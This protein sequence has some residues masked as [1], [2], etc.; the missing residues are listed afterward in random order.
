MSMLFHHYKQLT[1]CVEQVEQIEVKLERLLLLEKEK[2]G[3]EDHQ[4]YH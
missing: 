2:E 4:H 1:E 3:E